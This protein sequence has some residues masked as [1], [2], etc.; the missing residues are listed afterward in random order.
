MP[1]APETDDVVVINTFV[2]ASTNSWRLRVYSMDADLLGTY[3]HGVAPSYTD[4]YELDK[5]MQ[6]FLLFDLNGDILDIAAGD[7]INIDSLVVR[8]PAITTELTTLYVDSNGH[9]YTDSSLLEPAELSGATKETLVLTEDSVAMGRGETVEL[10]RVIDTDEGDEN[11][12]ETEETLTLTESDEGDENY[13]ATAETVHITEEQFVERG[14]TEEIIK[15]REYKVGVY[16][17]IRT[18]GRLITDIF[19]MDI[20]AIKFISAIEVGLTDPTTVTARIHYRFGKAEA[21]AQT[22]Y[23]R[24]NKEGVVFTMAA[25]VE[26]KLELQSTDYTSFKP[27]YITVRYKYPDKRYLRGP[28]AS[29]SNS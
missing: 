29:P 14:V 6:F 3:E 15:I 12:E 19:D 24:L 28:Y 2:G 11:Y 9:T 26:F 13:G 16:E 7:T 4:G 21:W 23:K 25:G 18:I 20:R 27:D 1:Y 5:D 10:V 17:D 22:T 8:L